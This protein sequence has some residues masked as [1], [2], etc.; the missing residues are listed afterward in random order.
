ML[1]APEP[2]TDTTARA[3]G[4]ALP[5]AI[6]FLI[7][8]L[9][10]LAVYC[11]PVMAP[12]AAP[13]LGMAPS[14]IGYYISITYFGAMMGS[15]TAG[16]VLA[17]Y[18]AIRVSQIALLLAFIGLAFAASGVLWLVLLGAL[19]V[20]LGYGPSTPASSVILLRASPPNLVAFTF[21]IKQTGVPAGAG[22]AGVLVPAL[23]PLIGWQA[24]ALVIGLTCLLMALAISSQRERYDDDRDSKARVSLAAAFAPVRLVIADRRLREIAFAGFVFGGVQITLVAYLVTFLTQSFAMTLALAGFVL[25]VSQIASVIG[26]IGWGIAADRLFTRRMMLGL[27]GVGMGLSSIA[28]LGASPQWP[29]WLLLVFAATFGATAV[30]WNGVWVA[31]VARIAPAGKVSGATGGCLFFTFL[32]VVITPAIFKFVLN[33]TGNYASAYAVFGLP[34]L[35]VGIRLLFWK[36]EK[37]S[38]NSA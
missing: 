3:G 22:L 29:Q 26:R 15:A 31:E 32:G 38:S 25:F 14:S 2:S 28:T 8:T 20:G 1:K 7:Q 19:L 4:V 11:A 33:L 9:G 21:S 23:I 37:A 6:T 12:V 27:L 36:G 10:A 35:C 30:G 5:L 34:A 24:S 16:G 17:R 18:G 13:A